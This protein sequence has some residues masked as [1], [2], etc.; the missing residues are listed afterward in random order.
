MADTGGSLNYIYF[1]GAP[2]FFIG[3]VFLT[4][5]RRRRLLNETPHLKK[6]YENAYLLQNE[7]ES[8]VN[9]KVKITIDIAEKYNPLQKNV[10]EYNSLIASL[11]KELQYTIDVVKNLKKKNIYKDVNENV[12][13]ESL[14]ENLSSIGNEDF[15]F[16]FTEESLQNDN[17]LIEFKETKDM[18]KHKN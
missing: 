5:S 18:L 3:L 1:S 9:S 4:R 12:I 15:H 7:I 10:A 6:V 2:L 14:R 11:M 16:L 17:K 13:I 8:L